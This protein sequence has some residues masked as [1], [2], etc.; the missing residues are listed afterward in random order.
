V[1]DPA[2]LLQ[3]TGLPPKAQDIASVKVL[4][5]IQYFDQVVCTA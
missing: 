2:I 1:K 5:E 3:E 4:K